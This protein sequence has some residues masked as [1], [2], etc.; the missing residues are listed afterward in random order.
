MSTIRSQVSN[1]YSLHPIFSTAYAYSAL[2]SRCDVILLWSRSLSPPSGHNGKV[3]KYAVTMF[4]FRSQ[5]Q[6][7]LY[8]SSYITLK[9]CTGQGNQ[10]PLD[11]EL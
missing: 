6:H 8:M 3:V 5:R 11:V 10:T 4:V 7:R 9:D 1:Y 2:R